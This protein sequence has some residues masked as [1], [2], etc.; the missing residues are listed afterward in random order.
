MSEHD[1][2]LPTPTCH[3]GRSDLSWVVVEL[4]TKDCCCCIDLCTM[5]CMPFSFLSENLAKSN[6][7]NYGNNPSKWPENWSVNLTMSTISRFPPQWKED[8]FR[9]FMINE[10]AC[11]QR[12]AYIPCSLNVLAAYFR[13]DANN[14][15]RAVQTH[16]EYKAFCSEHGY[17]TRHD[18]HCIPA[19]QPQLPD[20]LAYGTKLAQVDDSDSISGHLCVCTEPDES[21]DAADASSIES[22]SEHGFDER[23]S[24]QFNTTMKV[25]LDRIR[26][27]NVSDD[28]V[29]R[30]HL[31]IAFKNGDRKQY[32]LDQLK[33]LNIPVFPDVPNP[34]STEHDQFMALLETGGPGIGFVHLDKLALRLVNSARFKH[35]SYGDLRSQFCVSDQD[36]RV[37]R[38]EYLT[39]EYSGIDTES[40]SETECK[41]DKRQSSCAGAVRTQANSKRADAESKGIHPES[42]QGTSHPIHG[43]N[44]AGKR[45]LLNAVPARSASSPTVAGI[46]LAVCVFLQSEPVQD[47]MEAIFESFRL[48]KGRF[49]YFESNYGSGRRTQLKVDKIPVP[50]KSDD[51]TQDVFLFRFAGHWFFVNFMKEVFDVFAALIPRSFSFERF[52]D[53]HMAAALCCS[54]HEGPCPQ[55]D[56]HADKDPNRLGSAVSLLINISAWFSWFNILVNS[57]EN[58]A[59]LRAVYNRDYPLFYQ[60]IRAEFKGTEGKNKLY[61]SLKLRKNERR[62]MKQILWNFYLSVYVELHSGE[63]KSMQAASVAMTPMSASIFVTDHAHGGGEYPGRIPHMLR[64]YTSARKR[65]KSH[66]T[67]RYGRLHFR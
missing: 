6:E 24:R 23:T 39:D 49:G 40:D 5:T 64:E 32:E 9:Y 18:P 21:G 22:S 62:Q 51:E 29:N 38:D 35:Y 46:L 36:A 13:K 57:A 50:V 42:E 55:Q 25:V 60:A 28:F 54:A 34:T 10:D 26:N 31:H 48:T 67:Y 56:L 61:H 7:G 12:R 16:R 65:R 33:Q 4:N 66:W 59:C 47:R 8:L 27:G 53:P 20:S 3:F 44:N 15:R 30:K 45:Q 37:F 58:I 14:L 43:G 1:Q 52:Y 11:A 63:F 2:G 19:M 41:V 17:R